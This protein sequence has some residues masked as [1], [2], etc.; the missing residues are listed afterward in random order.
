MRIEI[1]LKN[2]DWF[3]A[4]EFFLLKKTNIQ[5]MLCKVMTQTAYRAKKG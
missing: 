5:A 2:G 3:G 1:S 4:D